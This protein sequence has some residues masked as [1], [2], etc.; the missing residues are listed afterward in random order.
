M[1]FTQLA[2]LPHLIAGII[3]LACNI[4]GLYVMVVGV[5]ISF[6][7]SLLDALTT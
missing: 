2:S 3:V 5:M 4:N 6:A 1:V 7:K